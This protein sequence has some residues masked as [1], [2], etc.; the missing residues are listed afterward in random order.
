MTMLIY[1]RRDRKATLRRGHLEGT[2]YFTIYDVISGE[3]IPSQWTRHGVSLRL[4][5]I[6]FPYI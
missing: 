3:I 5:Y 6:I 1:S 2:L 4:T